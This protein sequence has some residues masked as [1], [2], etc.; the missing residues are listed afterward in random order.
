MNLHQWAVSVARNL[1]RENFNLMKNK[2]KKATFWDS[3]II[4][5]IKYLIASAPK[6]FA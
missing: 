6:I 2:E 3:R 1:C 5:I 4:H